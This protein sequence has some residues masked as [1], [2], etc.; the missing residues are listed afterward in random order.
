MS[1][2]QLMDTPV[3]IGLMLFV[4]GVWWVRRLL[5]WLLMRHYERKSS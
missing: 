5:F 2:H 4:W 1:W 3:T